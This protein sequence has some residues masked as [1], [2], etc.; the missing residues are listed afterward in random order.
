VN[1]LGVLRLAWLGISG[2]ACASVLPGVVEMSLLLGGALLPR[3]KA[4]ACTLATSDLGRVAVVVPA[5]NEEAGIARTV[6]SLRRSEG[7]DF[8]VWVIADNCIDATADRAQHAGARVLVR[9]SDERRGKGY[10]LQ[11]AFEQLIASNYVGF[12]VV[13]ADTDVE[14]SF[15]RDCTAALNS[16]ADAVQ[17]AYFLRDADVSPMT[18]LASV[19]NRAFNGLRPLAR[20]RL[21]LSCHL[22]GNGFGLSRGTLLAVPY[23]SVSVVEDLEYHLALV[24]SARKVVF[25]D[26]TAVYG[27]TPGSNKSMQSQRT[28]WEGGRIRMLREQ[29]PKLLGD[30]VSGRLSC[31][32]PALDLMLLP[33]S[34]HLALL[35]LASTSPWMP[36]RVVGLFG[37]TQAVFYIAIA[38]IRCGGT[39]NEVRALV[40]APFYLISK[41]LMAR[42]LIKGSRADA[43]WTRT[44]R[45]YETASLPE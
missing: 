41:L 4:R 35:V 44:K 27:E 32:E 28:R 26:S 24:R 23:D 11:F 5:H 18:R 30:I 36:A 20:N 22:F 15:V 29:T 13:D 19:A 39:K 43:A 42:V 37:V 6:E 21:G 8:D 10:A 31:L 38:M 40:N 7:V 17:A 45:N 1:G 3:R 25:V 12:L 14:P 16:G 34:F 33:L 9:T 2:V